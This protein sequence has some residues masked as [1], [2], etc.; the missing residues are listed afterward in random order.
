MLWLGSILKKNADFI[1]GIQTKF[2]IVIC[3]KINP[4]FEGV[5]TTD[6]LIK[7]TI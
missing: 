2:K 4:K 1:E 5:L 3:S 6:I 7:P